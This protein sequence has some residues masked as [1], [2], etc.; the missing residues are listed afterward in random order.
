MLELGE[1]SEE[2][3]IKL[4]ETIQSHIF[5]KVFLVGPVFKKISVNSGF[6]AFY[7]VDELIDFL[8]HTPVKGK[9]I[10]IK[11]SRG[12]GLEKAYDML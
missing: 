9:T 10:L 3:H 8:K 2:E 5:G 4:L 11:G 1:K 12:I 7:T 6:K